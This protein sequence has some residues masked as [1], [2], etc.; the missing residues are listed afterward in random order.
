MEPPSMGPRR[1]RRIAGFPAAP[2]EVCPPHLKK[3]V[4]R[5]LDLNIEDDSEQISPHTLEDYAQRFQAPPDV[6]THNGPCGSLWMEP[7]CCCAWLR[8]GGVQGLIVLLGRALI[9]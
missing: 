6:R 7:P 8:V 4:M 9:F 1:S 5:A 3:R 2:A